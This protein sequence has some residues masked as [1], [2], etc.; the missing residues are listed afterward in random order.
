MI[1]QGLLLVENLLTG[2]AFQAGKVQPWQ[3]YLKRSNDFFAEAAIMSFQIVWVEKE[4]G[5]NL[6]FERGGLVLASLTLASLA[7][8]VVV[9]VH[10][11]LEGKGLAANLTLES[12]AGFLIRTLIPESL[13]VALQIGTI[14][15]SAAAVVCTD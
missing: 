5:A 12:V 13:L 9:G 15:E 10:F 6:A 8:L 2:F 3:R 7:S 4:I 11:S 1:A 14:C